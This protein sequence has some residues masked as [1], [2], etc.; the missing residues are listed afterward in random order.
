[1]Q[2]CQDLLYQREAEDGS[3]LDHIITGDEMWSQHYEPESKQQ[4]ATCEFPIEEKA[5][6][7]SLSR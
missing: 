1:M 2:V 6:D 7:V 4:V 3:F 5:Q